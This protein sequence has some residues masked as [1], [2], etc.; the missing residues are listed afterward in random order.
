MMSPDQ[1]HS[2]LSFS[3]WSLRLFEQPTLE[4]LTSLSY[5]SSDL[6]V[7]L[8]EMVLGVN[9]AI[10]ADWTII[11]VCSGGTGQ[12]LVSSH[13]LEPEDVSF[14]VHGT[15]AGEVMQSGRSLIIP[16]SD[17]DPR[18]SQLPNHYRGYLGVPLKTTKQVIIGTICSFWYKPRSFTEAE[19]TI[20]VAF[21]ERA[22]IAIENY[23]LYHQQQQ[24]NERLSEAMVACSVDLKQSQEK[25]TEHARLAAI[26]EFTA[27][28]V[29]EVRNP[30]TTIE[31]GLSHAQ[32]VLQS[33][34]DRERIAMAL[35]E[36][37]RLK[38][39][40][41]EILSYA[42]PQALQLSSLNLSDF[43][44]ELLVQI[45]NLPE[46]TDRLLCYE[47]SFSEIKVMADQDKLRQV[48]LNLFQ[49]AFEAIAPQE[50]VYC[51]SHHDDGSEW[52]WI[53]IHNG[54]RPIPPKL[55]AQIGTPFCSTKPDGIGL[56]LA[57]SKRI[58]T[59]HQ[60]ELK[61]E[62]SS[63]GTTVSVCLPVIWKDT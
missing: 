23:Q 1:P 22:A 50:T 27:M 8:T 46:A 5:Q 19:T 2:F 63:S 54:G 62:S 10:R 31:M 32:K 30:L 41:N 17:Q 13:D 34:V 3:D 55:L 7:Y 40:L 21:A 36:S 58:I 53:H 15:L 48:F 18:Q 12:I 42:K 33:D 59:A 14:S 29:H 20:V 52:I 45:R 6:K 16:D 56:G 35:S 24:F 47:K 28:I 49:N 57:I 25:L 9:R 37:Q 11:T 39:L 26:G 38:R 44:D 60:G 43:L 51:F 61:I 4:Y